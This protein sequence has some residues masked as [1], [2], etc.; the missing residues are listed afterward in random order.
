MELDLANKAWKM[1]HL[2]TP[3]MVSTFFKCFRLVG[4]V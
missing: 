3:D 1:T 2:K 4:M